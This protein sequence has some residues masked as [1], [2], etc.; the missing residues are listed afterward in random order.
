M[1]GKPA[2]IVMGDGRNNYNEANEWALEE[3]R[4]KAGY[5]LWLTPEER[6]LWRR[7][8]CLMELYGSYC[9]KVEVVSDVDQLSLVVEEL[10][11][12][13]YDHHDTRAWK[14]RR[15]APKEEE[16]YDYRSYYTRGGSGGKA[17]FDP[18][19]RRQW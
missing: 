9:D 10:L 5:M 8:D 14:R 7:G 15:P 11:H 18:E 1:R 17:G 3:I 19:V 2:I 12:T 13:L 16:P 4:E 6:E